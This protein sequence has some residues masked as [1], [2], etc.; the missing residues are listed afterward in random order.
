MLGLHN[1]ALFHYN[2]FIIKFFEVV[3]PLTYFKKT[4]LAYIRLFSTLMLIL[5]YLGAWGGG[6]PLYLQYRYR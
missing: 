1:I 4:T 6:A 2:H 3:F 5:L